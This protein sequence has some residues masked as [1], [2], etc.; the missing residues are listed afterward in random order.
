MS[1][2][3]FY[4]TP[5]AILQDQVIDFFDFQFT[6]GGGELKK[7]TYKGKKMDVAIGAGLFL[8]RDHY[9]A[10]T[11][12]LKKAKE[13]IKSQKTARTEQLEAWKKAKTHYV[14]HITK[15]EQKLSEYKNTILAF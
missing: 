8:V 7:C 12:K 10:K 3:V 9:M 5:P 6:I 11:E 14:D 13:I 4:T 15:A 1:N 2:E